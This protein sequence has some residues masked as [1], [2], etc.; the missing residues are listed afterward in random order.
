MRAMV[1]DMYQEFK[2]GQGEDTSTSK[3]DIGIEE[4]LL[5]GHSK[6][7]G[8]GK[9]PPLSTPPDSPENKKK[10]TSLINLDVNFD[11]PIYDG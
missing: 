2:K 8:K 6:G 10:K 5:D 3:Q 4:P 1:E 7:K 9:E 11:L